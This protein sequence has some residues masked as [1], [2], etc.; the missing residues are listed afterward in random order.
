[1]NSIIDGV[2]IGVVA[3]IGVDLAALFSRHLL[4]LPTTDWALSNRYRPLRLS[5]VCDRVR[6]GDACGALVIGP[7]PD[8]CG[9]V[10]NE[11]APPLADP[12]CQRLDALGIRSRVICRLGPG[13]L[14]E[15]P[16]FIAISGVRARDDRWPYQPARAES[17]PD[18]S[19]SGE[20]ML[21]APSK[22]E[23]V[24]GVEPT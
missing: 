21:T 3:T 19:G 11:H 10:R 20:Q 2:R 5:D 14:E 13:W 15:K 4:R 18:E 16:I 9:R 23:R 24:M 17:A 22:M 8:G 12:H 1:M 6:L 7:T